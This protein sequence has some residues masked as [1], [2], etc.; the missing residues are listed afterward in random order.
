MKTI[1]AKL[2]SFGFPDNSCAAIMG[3]IKAESDYR[4]NNVEN[5][6]GIDDDVY[7]KRVDAS[8]DPNYFIHDGHG[9]GL[10]QWTWWT[11]KKGLLEYCAK[12]N[13]SIADQDAQLE[14]FLIELQTDFPVLYSK[15]IQ[16]GDVGVLT[17]EFCRVFENPLNQ[18]ESVMKQRTQYAMD[19]LIRCS[20]VGQTIAVSITIDGVTY[21]GTLKA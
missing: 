11:R 19:A 6:S 4:S 12:R 20:T 13:K 15:L 8:V 7:T 18:N 16:G 10:F 21:T 17:A 3:N 2:K 1:W 14:Y 9:Y 5:A